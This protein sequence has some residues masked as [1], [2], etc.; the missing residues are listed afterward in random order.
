MPSKGTFNGNGQNSSIGWSISQQRKI[1]RKSLITLKDSTKLKRALRFILRSHSHPEIRFLSICSFTKE[2]FETKPKK[3]IEV[4]EQKF[5]QLRD[6][7]LVLVS[8][9]VF[10]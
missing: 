2:K 8:V 1:I 3:M 6:R 9:F 7:L 5:K 4:F 10:S